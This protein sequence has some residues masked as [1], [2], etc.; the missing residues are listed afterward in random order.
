MSN[1]Y[2]TKYNN[3]IKSIRGS[4]TITKKYPPDTNQTT[5]EI[6]K[7]IKK[8]VNFIPPLQL[9]TYNINPQDTNGYLNSKDYIDDVDD[10]DKYYYTSQQIDNIKIVKNK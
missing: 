7:K 4:G 10:I 9:T 6:T 5:K 8:D 1:I 3:N 2:H